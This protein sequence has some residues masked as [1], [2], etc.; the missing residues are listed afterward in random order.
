[1]TDPTHQEGLPRSYFYR[2]LVNAMHDIIE[3]EIAQKGPPPE[4]ADKVDI[5]EALGRLVTCPVCSRPLT[6]YTNYPHERVCGSCGEFTVT[7]VW[8]TGDVEF[9]FKMLGAPSVQEETEEQHGDHGTL[10]G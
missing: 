8:L 5:Q 9:T 10:A 7:A 6:T 1:M 2:R 3:R 4:M